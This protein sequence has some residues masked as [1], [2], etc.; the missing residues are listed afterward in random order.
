MY[1][2]YTLYNRLCRSNMLPSFLNR[3]SVREIGVK[4][5]YY[6]TLPCRSEKS[7]KSWRSDDTWWTKPSIQWTEF[8]CPLFSTIGVLISFLVFILQA[9]TGCLK[10]PDKI[11]KNVY[12]YIPFIFKDL[13][14]VRLIV[15]FISVWP[16]ATFFLWHMYIQSSTHFRKMSIF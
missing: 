3:I 10:K 4:F 5:C 1:P 8:I 11:L 12:F 6:F 7:T 2:I 15:H 16:M 9:Y 14:L 13:N